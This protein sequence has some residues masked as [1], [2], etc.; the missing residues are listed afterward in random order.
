MDDRDRQLLEELRQAIDELEEGH[1]D[2]ERV[3]E[4]A[5]SIERRLRAEAELTDEDDTLA[6]DL[7]E[8]AVR[9]EAD[10]PRLAGVLRQAVDLF[11]GIGL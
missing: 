3:A 5:G 8:A 6:E 7:H 11:G 4:L 1:G 9:L 10:H 2:R